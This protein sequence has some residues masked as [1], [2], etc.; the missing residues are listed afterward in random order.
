MDIEQLKNASAIQIKTYHLNLLTPLFVHGWQKESINKNNKTVSNPVS[1]EW[2]VPSWRGI[3]R[4]WWRT[5]QIMG[6]QDM[7]AEEELHFGGA[8]GNENAMKSK[9]FFRFNFRSVNPHNEVKTSA[10]PSA[11]PKMK[12]LALP[13]NQSIELNMYL[14]KR[15]ATE[16]SFY[17]NLC[18]YIFMVAGIGQRVRRGGGALQLAEWKDVTQYSDDLIKNLKSQRALADFKSSGLPPGCLL[19]RVQG[20]AEH[21]ILMSVWLGRGHQDAEAVRIAID[22]A[23]NVANNPDN[24]QHLGN[25]TS[26]R[27]SSPLWCTVRRI[28]DKYYPIISEV[29]NPNIAKEKYTEQKQLFLNE[30]GVGR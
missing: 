17:E 22:H 13:A 19:Q 29:N 15:H 9:V 30:L 25:S 18:E 28:G 6:P 23:A 5:L 20:D 11:L 27:L 2:R 26:P 16:Q 4:Y 14:A 21:P 7:R 24:P 10:C 3:M 1:A 12:I 8:S